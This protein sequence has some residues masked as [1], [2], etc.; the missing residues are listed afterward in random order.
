MTNQDFTIVQG[1]TFEVEF[2]LKDSAGS[3][4]NLAGYTPLMQ[5]R[6]SLGVE[7]L[8][9]AVSSGIVL[10]EASGL[11]EATVTATQSALI[12][13]ARYVYQLQI[14]KAGVVTTVCE[15]SLTVRR[16]LCR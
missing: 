10:T 11:I 5:I 7:V 6:N 8:E 1:D 14:T 15:G 13:P 9:L 3:I 2:N 16:D 4:I 12:E